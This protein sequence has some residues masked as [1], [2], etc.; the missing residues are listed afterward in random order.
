MVLIM[1]DIG[2]G[3][4][5]EAVI[6]IEEARGQLAEALEPATVASPTVAP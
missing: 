4:M 2:R 3:G 6:A 5:N 1:A